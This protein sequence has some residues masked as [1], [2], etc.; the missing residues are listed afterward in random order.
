MLT[1][2]ISKIDDCNFATEVS[3]SVDLLQAI[4]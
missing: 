4:R 3:K 1:H 2:V